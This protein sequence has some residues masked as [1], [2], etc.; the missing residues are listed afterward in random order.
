[1]NMSNQGKKNDRDPL[2][3][4]ELPLL[5]PQQDGW[6]HIRAALEQQ[7]SALAPTRSRKPVIA[8]ATAASIALAVVVFMGLKDTSDDQ[9]DTPTLAQ[10]SASEPSP[11]LAKPAATDIDTLI[12][13]SQGL[14]NR[15]INLREQTAF[16]P[17]RSALFVAELEDTIAQVDHALSDNP[18][19]LDLWAQRVN[20]LLDLELLYQRQ[21]EREFG[22]MA[23]L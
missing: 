16:L 21:W 17:A 3:L 20:L 19:A 7:Q 9:R 5:E 11:T 6:T 23:S 4:S 10:H 8:W 18:Q 14:E 1:M 2:G 13:L 22:R 12:Q 15:L